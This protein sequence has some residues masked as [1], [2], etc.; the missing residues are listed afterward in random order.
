MGV[1]NKNR[2]WKIHAPVID[3]FTV[4]AEQVYLS[5]FNDV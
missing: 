4:V 2:G 5:L 3:V 1:K